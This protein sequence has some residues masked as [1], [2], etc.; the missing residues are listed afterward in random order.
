MDQPSIVKPGTTPEVFAAQP[1]DTVRS[2]A[3]GYWHA[4]AYPIDMPTGAKLLIPA[5]SDGFRT[6]ARGE[7]VTF[8]VKSEQYPG[9][10]LTTYAVMGSSAKR[11]AVEDPIEKRVVM[12]GG[13]YPKPDETHEEIQEVRVATMDYA[14]RLQ[15]LFKRGK[16]DIGRAIATLDHLQQTQNMAIDALSLPHVSKS[17]E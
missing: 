11:V 3:A 15:T 16:V 5:S 2:E 12:I 17:S 7:S 1:A 10:Q 6:L 8:P 13:V 4:P 14:T 9:P